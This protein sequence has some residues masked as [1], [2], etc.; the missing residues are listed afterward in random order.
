MDDNKRFDV[1]AL[2]KYNVDLVVI[3]VVNLVVDDQSDL[4]SFSKRF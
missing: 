1:K 2:I 3:L 4:S